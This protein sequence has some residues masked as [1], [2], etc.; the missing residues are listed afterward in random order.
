MKIPC[1]NANAFKKCKCKFCIR[2]KNFLSVV[3]DKSDELNKIQ[4]LIIKG[5]NKRRLKRLRR[6]K[7]EQKES[8]R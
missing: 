4:N 3:Y 8:K 6:E 5:I 7:K 2:Y 1:E